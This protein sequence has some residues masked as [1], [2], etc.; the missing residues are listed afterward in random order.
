MNTAKSKTHRTVLL[1]VYRRLE[2]QF[3]SIPVPRSLGVPQKY[4]R[5]HLRAICPSS[6]NQKSPFVC[7]CVC[8][9]VCVLSRA[10]SKVS[11]TNEVL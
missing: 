7:V 6:F 9:C 1:R 4:L 2:V 3:F 5:V 11:V 10:L 8:V